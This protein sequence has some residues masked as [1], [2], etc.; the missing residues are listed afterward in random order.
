MAETADFEL[1]QAVRGMDGRISDPSARMTSKMDRSKQRRGLGNPVAK[2]REVSVSS[3]FYQSR[4]FAFLEPWLPSCRVLPSRTA[5][6]PSG[7]RVLPRCRGAESAES[8][9]GCQAVRT[10]V[11]FRAAELPS[12]RAAELPS[13]LPSG[14]PR[15][16]GGPWWGMSQVGAWEMMQ[17]GLD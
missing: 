12:C 4:F 11:H 14:L 16:P 10:L 5:E 9:E 6:L 2:S 7:C 17:V 13:G 8:A 1:V 3:H 15:V